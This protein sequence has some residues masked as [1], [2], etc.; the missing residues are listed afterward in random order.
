MRPTPITALSATA[1]ALALVSP[2]TASDVEEEWPP[3]L[4]GPPTPR[5]ELKQWG[6]GPFEV[7][8]PSI[9]GQLRASPMAR[10]PRTLE[11]GV[12][13]GGI[14]QTQESTYQ[15][16]DGS[17]VADRDGASI[18]RLTVDGETRDTH[19]VLRLGVWPRVELGAEFDA[20]H[21]QG[22]GFL[23][24]LVRSFHSTMGMGTMRRDRVRAHSWDVEASEPNGRT[25]SLAHG[26]GTGDLYLSPRVLLL[27]GGDYYP[28]V[29]MTF[30]LWVPTASA[31][32]HHAKGVAETLS[33]DASKRLGTLPIVLYFGG[34]F[35]NYDQ[36]RIEGIQLTRQ[37]YMG[38]F[39][40]EVE[41]T[42]E[43]SLVTHFWQESRREQALYR[44]T[45]SQKGN[46]IQYIAAGVK[47]VPIPGVRIE[48]GVL[49]SFDKSVGGD[50]GFLANVWITFGAGGLVDDRKP[51]EPDRTTE[52]AR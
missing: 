21:Y 52:Q 2:V 11:P 37:R 48:V 7:R 34:A 42:P 13:E 49:E 20:V 36:A 23:D 16:A 12:A 14:R 18:H 32:F 38:Y 25:F 22:G 35:T 40:F 43:V 46:E 24:G 29:S 28:A 51:T 1:L 8:D 30:S 19:L 4:E 15:Y 27:E 50:F 9:L 47:V 3:S 44:D 26:T 5:I 39:G 41:L 45:N 33:L 6:L 31:R 10:S 17:S